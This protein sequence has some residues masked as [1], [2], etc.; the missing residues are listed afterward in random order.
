M[1]FVTLASLGAYVS[2]CIL[3]Y[4][5]QERVV[6]FPMRSGE[7][8]SLALAPD[9][10]PVTL[11]TSDALHLDALVLHVEGARGALL[12][13]HGNAGNLSHRLAAAREFR[14][15]H[16]CVLLFD[17]RGYGRSEGSPSEEG[18]Y[19]DAEAAY[20]F[21]RTR[22]FS[23]QQIAL[24][25]E[26]LGGAVAIELA[27]RREVAC[28]LSESSFTSVPDL[29]A[30]IYR[31]LPVRRLARIR[32]ENRAKIA[33]LGIPLLI[34]HSR[35]DE[36]VPFHHAAELYEHAREPKQLLETSGSHNAGGFLCS[37]DGKDRVRAFLWQNLPQP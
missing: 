21:L 33:S 15:M 37:P 2:I 11:L 4:V 7:S 5:F 9:C 16:V 8:G 13:C 24:Y 25:G 36:I 32:F 29:G 35:D 23:P 30:E 17:Y 34:L 31:W 6:F 22:G 18:T 14:D 12:F 27:R 3:L 26:S 19:T 10:E 28:L 1:I 20:D